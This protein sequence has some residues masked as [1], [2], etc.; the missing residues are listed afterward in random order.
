MIAAL[1]VFGIVSYKRVGVDLFPNVEFPLVTVL[2]VYPGA[3]PETMETKVADLIEEQINTMGGIR[4]LRSVNMEGATQVIAMFELEV[5][6]DRALQDVR[7]RV[8]RIE[9]DLPEGIDPPV[10]QKMDMGAAPVL[11]LALAGELPTRELTRIADKVVKQRIERVN[12][13]G[14]VDIIGGRDREIQVL[15]DPAKLSGVG[16]TVSDVAQALKAQNL[17]LPA[18]NFNLGA[19]EL[20]VKTK[21]EVQT[22]EQIANILLPV[23]LGAPLR[24]RDVARVVDGEEEARS[25][26]ALDGTRAV[27]LVVRKQS[28]VNTVAV[29]EAVRHA[30]DE[31]G[32]QLQRTGARMTVARDNAVFIEHSIEDVQFDL[33]FGGLLAVVIIFVLLMDMRATFISA[34]AI[35]TSVVA[36]FG[37]IQ[38]MGF[39][40]NN[41]TMLAL[42]LSI[43]ILID[44][45]IVVIENIHRH[46]EQ[47]KTAMQAAADATN[48]IFLAVLAMTS[49]IIAVFL[50]VATMRG[51]IGRFFYQFGMTVSFAVAVSMLVSFTLTPMLASRFLTQEHAHRKQNLLARAVV[52][53]MNWLEARYGA[54]VRWSLHHRAVT[55]AFAVLAL[56]GSGV[57][58][59]RVPSEFL[60]AE[61][62]SEFQV[63]VETPTGTNLETSQKAVLSVAED[64][65]QHAPG[66]KSVLA[67][68]GG[69]T[70]GQVTKGTIEIGLVKSAER[71]FSQ[72]ELMAWMRERYG[73]IPN[74]TVSVADIN[75]FSSG[76]RTQPVQFNIRGD[77]LEELVQAGNALVQE[78]S[79]V[80][81]FVDLDTSY[82]GG[83]PEIGIEI[84]RD[85]AA[86]LGVPV[87]TVATTMRSFMAGDAVTELKQGGDTYDVIL[88][89]DDPYR[90]RV[91][92]LANLKVRSSIQSATG[93]AL[94]D[95]SN[96]VRAERGEGPSQ[97]E[98]QA[99]QKQ[100][101]VLAALEGVALGDAMKHV[102]EA[103]DRVV[104]KH[105]TTDFGGQ[106]KFMGESFGYMVQALILAVILVYMILGAQFNSFIQPI[107]IMLSLPLS[108]IGAFGALYVSGMRLSIFSMIGII[109][110]MG[111][112]TKN[113][114]LLVDFANQRR[115]SGE[116]MLDAL[117]HAGVLRLRPILMTTAAMVF[118]M[119]PVAMALSEGGEARAP[120]AVCVIG[121]LITSTLLTLV[122]VPVVYT[123]F[124]D[125]T[126]NALVRR[127]EAII[128]RRSPAAHT[129]EDQHSAAE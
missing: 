106:A 109:M 49:S 33:V 73:K 52:S 79:K 123:L 92:S 112:V 25:W 76:E 62:R 86:A 119:L 87:S 36:T 77:N 3:D 20:S 120:M 101:T 51:M 10:V 2:V 29:A 40:F 8:G 34:V 84:D 80:K 5:P 83:R 11:T 107:T 68:V 90:A 95:L 60:P 115:E 30:V 55:V 78:L 81:G 100:V 37:F 35:P 54:V 74:L 98:R 14:G 39:T 71:S 67:S 59:S 43:G 64:I 121:G 94:V 126:H 118:G 19:Q 93:P 41:M 42:S 17:E 6:V 50:P 24:V 103:A 16:L 113:A 15:V 46:L 108:V 104:P 7:D 48:E 102:T 23:N 125:L 45:A 114:I 28:G 61:D 47:G 53:S 88:R 4:E 105:L 38:V 96:L 127:L 129:P 12:G 58:V 27:S 9:R 13:V 99:R 65:R 72:Q 91:E 82:A 22:A 31:L 70:G 89:L 26:S 128:F 97:I 117:V 18:G 116:G 111:L 1:V 85:R 122:V 57:L 69:G 44:D 21:G 75:Q 124:D 32:P 110:L 66:V 63:S 56:I